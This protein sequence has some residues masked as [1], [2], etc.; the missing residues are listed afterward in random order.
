MK[1]CQRR[2]AITTPILMK[3]NIG[4]QKQ[5][6]FYLVSK[7]YYEINLLKLNQQ[8]LC[9]KV[10]HKLTYKPKTTKKKKPNWETHTNE[11]FYLLNLWCLC[12]FKIQS[13]QHTNT[14]PEHTNR[15]HFVI[16]I[17]KCPNIWHN[18]QP[19]LTHFPNNYQLLITNLIQTSTNIKP[20]LVWP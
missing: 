9:I 2:I 7:I 6:T 20:Q 14:K 12:F 5:H 19:N 11:K 10:N 17:R 3:W 1:I 15:R 16:P 4:R 18:L 13:Q 8:K